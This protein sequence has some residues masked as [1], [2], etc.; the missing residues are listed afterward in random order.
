[1]QIGK[2]EHVGLVHTC[3]LYLRLSSHEYGCAS[4]VVAA[5]CSRL[6]F[7]V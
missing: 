7:S 4:A 3:V 1:M 5:V 6:L 2:V